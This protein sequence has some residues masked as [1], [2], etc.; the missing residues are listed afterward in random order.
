MFY[1]R[2]PSA[3]RLVGLLAEARECSPT[4]AE[5]GAT[6]D[7]AFPTGYRHD[8]DELLVGR[9]REAFDQAVAAVQAWQAQLGAGV[10]VVPE[11]EEVAEGQTVLLLIRGLGLWTVAPCRVVYTVEDA[12]VYRFAYA[13]LPGH[14]ERGEASFAVKRGTH[15]EVVFRVAS[16]SRP[17]HP[18]AR[19]GKPLTRRLQ[20]QVT[21]RYLAAIE[22]AV[23]QQ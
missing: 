7:A 12:D 4:Y 19:L 13:T 14:P 5:V 22:A 16:F 10:E 15:D 8:T 1:A 21:V 2:R 3:K 20:R 18:L 9:G 11:G 6:R 23:L 17:A